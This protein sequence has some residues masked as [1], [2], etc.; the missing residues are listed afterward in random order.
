MPESTATAADSAV[1]GP[2]QE[3]RGGNDLSGTGPAVNIPGI[4]NFGGPIATTADAGFGFTQGIFQVVNNF[5]Y[6]GGNHSYKFGGDVQLIE[7][8]RT[9][10]LLQL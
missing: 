3:S 4:A 7:D 2:R 1:T 5:S 10:T 8:T 6:V 9:S